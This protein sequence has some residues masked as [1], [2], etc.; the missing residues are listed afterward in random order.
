MTLSNT[1]LKCSACFSTPLKYTTMPSRW[2]TTNFH[3]ISFKNKIHCLLKHCKHIEQ[4]GRHS[5]EFIKPTLSNPSSYVFL[6]ALFNLYLIITAF[7]IYH[8]TDF[9]FCWT[10]LN[11]ILVFLILAHTFPATSDTSAFV[12]KGTNI[13]VFLTLSFMMKGLDSLLEHLLMPE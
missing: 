4:P 6:M 2:G 7:S 1:I 3:L 12:S 10:T 11:L 8:R 5:I 9:N 13:S